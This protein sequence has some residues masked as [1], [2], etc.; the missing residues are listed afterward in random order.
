MG[1][2]ATTVL[3]FASKGLIFNVDAAWSVG[4]PVRVLVTSWSYE[5]T[6]CRFIALLVALLSYMSQQ[7]VSASGFAPNLPG[8]NLMI[9]LNYKRNLDH[10]AWRH[11]RTF[12]SQKYTRFLWSVNTSTRA[13]VPSR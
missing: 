5:N 6:S 7:C 3:M 2:E 4:D 11:N 10:L 13:G 1:S 9:R 8:L 12:D